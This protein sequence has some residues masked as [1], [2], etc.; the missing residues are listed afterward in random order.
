MG[1][2]TMTR[3]TDQIVLRNPTDA[4]FA[5]FIAPLSIAF[6]EEVSDA[7]IENERRTLELDRFYGAL[8]GGSGQDPVRPTGRA[9]WADPDPRAGRGRR[10]LPRCLRRAAWVDPRHDRPQPGPP[11]P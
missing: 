2:G 1:D 8:A 4:E 3:M 7:A 11:A 9:A 5:R 6:N 10:A